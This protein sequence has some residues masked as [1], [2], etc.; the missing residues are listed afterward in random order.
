MRVLLIIAVLSLSVQAENPYTLQFS[1]ESKYNAAEHAGSPLGWLESE[2]TMGMRT[3][4][5]F[6]S[7]LIKFLISTTLPETLLLLI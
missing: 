2:S 6:L 7:C 3:V 1:T 4:N 5:V